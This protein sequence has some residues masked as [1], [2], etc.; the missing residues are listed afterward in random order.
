VR[1]FVEWNWD[2]LYYRFT[3]FFPLT[4]IGLIGTTFLLHTGW[5]RIPAVIVVIG[6]AA[7]TAIHLVSPVL[8]ASSPRARAAVDVLDTSVLPVNATLSRKRR[9][10]AG[11][12]WLSRRTSHAT[13]QR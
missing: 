6:W 3:L 10:A 1:V 9:Q 4:L 2:G 5:L 7:L 8:E 12:S 13:T 11:S